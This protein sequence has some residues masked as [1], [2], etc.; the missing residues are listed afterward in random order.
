MSDALMTA[1]LSKA[2][3][4]A[5]RLEKALAS[6][7]V[8]LIHAALV[9]DPVREAAARRILPQAAMASRQAALELAVVRRNCGE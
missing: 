3:N 6:A 5:C 7:E 9:G 8:V 1:T 2:V 4:R